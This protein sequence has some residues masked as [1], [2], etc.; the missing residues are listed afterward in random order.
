MN[1]SLRKGFQLVF[2]LVEIASADDL[3]GGLR[4]G[5][6]LVAGNG[7]VVKIARQERLGVEHPPPQLPGENL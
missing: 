2:E 5:R 3:H 1:P 4:G 6:I 7:E